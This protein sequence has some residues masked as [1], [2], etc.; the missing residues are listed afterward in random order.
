MKYVRFEDL[1]CWQKAR[2][3]CSAV[4]DI[5]SEALFF[6]DFGLRDQI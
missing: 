3:L 2:Q 1:P 6:K 4:F 5:I